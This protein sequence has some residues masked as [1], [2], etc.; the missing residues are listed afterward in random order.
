MPDLI[1]AVDQGT[2]STRFL[3][4]DRAGAVVAGHQLEHEQILPRP[5]WVEHNPVEIWERTSAV[6][7]TALNAHGLRAGDLAALGVTNQRETTVVWDRRT[8]R[9]YHN[10]IVWQDTRTDRIAADLEDRAGALIRHRTGLPPA[11]YFSGGKLRW[12]LDTVEGLRAAAD[13]GDAL[14]GTIDSWLLWNLTGGPRG[15]VHVTDVTNA[16]R[17][18]LMDL[19]TLDWDDELLALFG[20]P[21]AMLPSIRPSSDPDLYGHTAAHG[22]LGGEV[23]LAAAVGDQQA[24]MIGQVCFAPGEAKNT[25][26]TGNF[27]LLNTGTTPMRSSNGLLTTVCY[28][29]GSAAP[30]YALEGSIAVT[31]SA[32]QWLRDQLG[33]IQGASQSE[34][35]AGEVADNGGVYFVPAFSGLYAPHWR[36]DARGAIVGLTRY[37]TNAHIARATL[38]AICYQTR[39]VADAMV[40]DSGVALEVLKVDGGVTANNLCMR[41]QADVLGVP[42]SRPVVAETTALGAAY[43]AGL[44]VGFWGGTDELR[45]NW[46]ESARWQ[47]E[48]TPAQ[49]AAGYEGWRKAVDRTLD[50]VP[51]H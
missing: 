3:V 23:A 26:G 27:L 38:E 20:I 10:A 35:L 2:T 21:R 22:P 5:G 48:W 36:S 41:I 51:T 11:P 40:K 12:L 17:T 8:G 44:A 4:F 14:F 13:R 25:Y 6:I 28:Q 32:V 37:A 30:V 39:D 34:T 49:R 19:E 50:W 43:A 42:V 18:M 16:S 45:R 24:A 7:Q 29:L 9:P 33:I 31:G 15:G 47:P 46:R 1:G